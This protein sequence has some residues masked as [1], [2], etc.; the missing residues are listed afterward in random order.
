MSKS[1]TII[2]TSVAS[3]AD[4]AFSGYACLFGQVDLGRDVIEPGA[5]RRSLAGQGDGDV[6]MLYQHDPHQPIGLWNSIVEDNIG[7]RVQGRLLL[8]LRSAQ[9]VLS[10]MR[11]GILSGLSIGFR[12]RNSW[13]NQRS[14]LRYI[15]TA[16]LW[17]ISIVTFPMQTRARVDSIKSNTHNRTGSILQKLRSVTHTIN[18]EEKRI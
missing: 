8:E 6:K 16:D 17:E 15:R 4:G 10:L 2:P 12:V 3:R 7:L 13:R 9:E 1:T 18:Q 5:F 11:A 14:R